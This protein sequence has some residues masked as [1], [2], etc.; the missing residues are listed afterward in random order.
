MGIVSF[1]QNREDVRLARV[2]TAPTGFY[3]D[4]GAS[5]PTQLSITRHFSDRGWHGV[6]IEPR[7]AGAAALRDARPR[8]IT[9]ESAAGRAAG[10]ATFF[11]MERSELGEVSTANPTRAADSARS[12]TP[13][14]NAGC[15]S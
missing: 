8:D 13:S 14:S 7:P 15:P 3:I 12:D 10:E 11:E 6:N 1:A 2:L 9:V 4:V 5:R